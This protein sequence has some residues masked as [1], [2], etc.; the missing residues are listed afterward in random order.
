MVSGV[1][2][3][4]Q[5]NLYDCN[6]EFNNLENGI[7]PRNK[8]KDVAEGPKY[9]TCKFNK[10]L[11]NY[12]GYLIL[13]TM[14]VLLFSMLSMYFHNTN[15]IENFLLLFYVVY[16]CFPVALPTLYFVWRPKHF[17]IAMKILP[18]YN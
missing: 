2:N 6:N 1:I 9:N 11:I 5:A 12:T 16:S 18:C 15:D 7:N 10:T 4:Q 17:F 3:A 14:I 13:F 8:E